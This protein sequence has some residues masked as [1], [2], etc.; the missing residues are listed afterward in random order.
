MPG[1]RGIQEGARRIRA[2]RPARARLRGATTRRP[3]PGCV[4]APRGVRRNRLLAE[5]CLA[6]NL[7]SQPPRPGWIERLFSWGV[8]IA[9]LV[10]TVVGFGLLVTARHQR[11][12]GAAS[13]PASAAATSSVLLATPIDSR[14]R[15][16]ELRGTGDGARSTGLGPPA[17]A[18]DCGEQAQKV[19]PLAGAP[20]RQP[21]PKVAATSSHEQAPARRCPGG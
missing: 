1:M 11:A 18:V 13:T 6:L 17:A 15:A 21:P 2:G 7:K 10:T 12:A 9:M 20:G 16:I 3:G 5:E 4:T 19:A 14:L 8:A